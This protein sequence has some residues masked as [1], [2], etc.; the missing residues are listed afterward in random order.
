MS[1]FSRRSSLLLCFALAGCSRASATKPEPAPAGSGSARRDAAPPLL[2]RG[3]V[4]SEKSLNVT[5]PT[6]GTLA[7]NESVK[8]VS[9]ISRRLLKIHV[10]EGAQVKKGALLFSLDAADASASLRRL[11]VRKKLLVSNEGRSK[12][13]LAQN[14]LSQAEYDRQKSELDELGAEI[15]ATGVTLAKSRI[16]A[17]FGGKIGLRRVSVGAWV[18]PDTVLTTLQDTS[19]LKVDFSL[20]ERYAPFVRVGHKFS[21]Q[22][23]GNPQR[24]SGEVSAIEPE[25]DRS[26]RSVTLRGVTDNS[27]DVLLPGAFANVEVPLGDAKRVLLV[28][29]EAL[30]PSPTGQSLWLL[31]DGKASLVSVEVGERTA[32]EVEVVRG[33]A[34]GDTVLVT[35]LLRLRNGAA[36]T[37]EK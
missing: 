27:G 31:R 33:V 22:V 11:E 37:L 15:A 8:I 12:Q 25:V 23:T 9:E 34:S 24:F 6:V 3:Y 28:P 4:V 30:V 19:K 36:V 2:A 7:S 13:L 18:T 14:L 32:S 21:F 35:N 16:R 5:V 26:T 20:P 10:S 1:S 29:A 17:P